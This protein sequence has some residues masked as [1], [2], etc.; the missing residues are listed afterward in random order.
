MPQRRHTKSA[1]DIL[2]DT[3]FHQAQH[4]IGLGLHRRDRLEFIIRLT[5]AQ[6]LFELGFQALIKLVD[7]F[8]Q[9]FGF[10]QQNIAT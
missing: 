8:A 1:A 9:T 3:A 5:F 6:H 4:Q 7:A 10:P 2:L